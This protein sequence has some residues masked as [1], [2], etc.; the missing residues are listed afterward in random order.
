MTEPNATDP[1]MTGA[2]VT[3]PDVAGPPVAS[4][5][6]AGPPVA[7]QIVAGPQVL[8]DADRR[9]V[10]WRTYQAVQAEQLA[11]G[12]LPDVDRTVLS[13]LRGLLALAGAVQLGLLVA[14]FSVFSIFVV[15]RMILHLDFSRYLGA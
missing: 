7:G 2:N 12:T 10:L 1:G 13:R 4:P 9:E 11:K 15:T 3:G 6:V 14:S 8:D 5:N